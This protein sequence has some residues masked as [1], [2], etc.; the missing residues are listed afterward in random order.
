MLLPPSSLETLLKSPFKN[1]AET[2]TGADNARATM[3]SS[4]NALIP[5]FVPL[6]PGSQNSNHLLPHND[7]SQFYQTA[8]S[9]VMD[10]ANSALMF[11]STSGGGGAGYLSSLSFNSRG[12]V[13]ITDPTASAGGG[14]PPSPGY[15]AEEMPFVDTD[16]V[17]LPRQHFSKGT[18]GSPPDFL[19][20][21]AAAASSLAHKC[22][23]ASRL[24]MF[25]HDDASGVGKGATGGINRSAGELTMS[26]ETGKDGVGNSNSSING[27]ECL[28][29]F[30]DFGASLNTNLQKLAL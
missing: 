1:V 4:M 25:A 19:L 18:D 23:T 22:A 13:A 11:G 30:R 17:A 10:S 9:F 26:M 3:W 8:T 14:A 24:S 16:L 28:A 7:P 6:V 15:L 12:S 29:E 21:S 20:S 5:P 2:G 27:L